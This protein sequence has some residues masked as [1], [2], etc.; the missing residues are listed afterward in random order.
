MQFS[1]LTRL[2]GACAAMALTLAAQSA[3]AVCLIGVPGVAFGPYDPR[4]AST[5]DGAGTLT[6]TGCTAAYTIALSTGSSNSYAP[7]KM[8]AGPY[9]LNYNLY[10]DSSFT[11]VWGDG[12]GGTSVRS[13]SGAPDGAAYTVHGRIPAGQNLGAGSYSDQVIV[14]VT[15]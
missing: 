5:T 7:R 15:F 1:T 11:L 2:P 4:S 12:T 13:F 6:F 14:T 8:A 9:N 3:A 10:T